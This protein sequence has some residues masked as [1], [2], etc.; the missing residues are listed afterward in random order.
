MIYYIAGPNGFVGGGDWDYELVLTPDIRY[1]Y[2]FE[3]F[4]DADAYAKST[5]LAKSYYAILCTNVR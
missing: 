5:T 4:A 1:A 2:P 3:T